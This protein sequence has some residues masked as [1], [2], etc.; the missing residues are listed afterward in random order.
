[1]ESKVTTHDK[2]D[3]GNWWARAASIQENV[4]NVTIANVRSDCRKRVAEVHGYALDGI[5]PD[6]VRRIQASAD[7]GR[8]WV[9]AEITYREGRW[10]WA[11]WKA[12]VPILPDENKGEKCT[13][14]IWARLVDEH[15]QCAQAEP[16]QAQWNLRFSI[17][18]LEKVQYTIVK[19]QPSPAMHFA[20]MAQC[21]FSEDDLPESRL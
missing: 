11:L 12:I 16:E 2:A 7:R 3:A 5:A 20:L 13:R 9:E 18:K 1:M 17:Q 15:G 4:P 8:T 14:V 21:H 10:S 19:K 6:G